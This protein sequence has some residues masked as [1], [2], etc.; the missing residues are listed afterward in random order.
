LLLS[1]GL[2]LLIA[3]GNV[4]NLLLGEARGREHE[5]AMR[6]ALGA[7][8]GRIV[9]QLVI[10]SLA[11]SGLGGILG[12][13]VA[14]ISLRGLV[15]L[16][17]PGL[18]RINEIGVDARILFFVTLLSA[19]SGIIF[20][21]APALTLAG[22]NLVDTLKN[23]GQQKGSPRSRSQALVVVTEISM[24]FVLLVGPGLLARSLMQLNA[25]DTGFNPVNLLAVR[26][27]LP[28]QTYDGTKVSALY[29]QMSAELSSLPGISAVTATDGAPFQD[30]R[31][32]STATIDGKPA[33]LETRSIWPNYFE[34][35]G[36][37]FLEGRTFSEAEAVAKPAPGPL[38]VVINQTMAQRFWPQEKAT[39]KRIEYNK[40]AHPPVIG[41][42]DDVRQLGLAVTPPPMFYMPMIW[43][44][45]FTLLIRTTQNPLSVAPAVRNRIRSI[46]KNIAI[47]WI[48]PI[49]E[50]IRSS[51]I[52]ERYRALLIAMFALSAA[53]LAVVGLYGVMSRYVA[54]R[55]RE[56]G[57]RL[58]I[59]AQPRGVMALVLSKGLILTACGIVIGGIAAAW[60]TRVLSTYLFGISPLDTPTYVAVA[61]LLA[62]I[63]IAAVIYPARRASRIDPAECLRAE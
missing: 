13:V 36:G 24:C 19:A 25:V 30:R 20:G 39:D 42:T 10:E 18:P 4:A 50:M 51:L 29:R 22:T 56:F 63:S 47:D 48:E 17:P 41:V 14:W 46:D 59:G 6:S 52:E 21:L 40:D 9:R 34:V 27:A 55:N 35:L 3:C 8:T 16:A 54:Y 60:T 44:T 11:I 12:C 45:D 1:S 28:R 15:A 57:I 58:A 23:R 26:V 49:T 7:S 2:L 53:L 37:R 33:V 61:L 38:A 31:S 5:V 32:V 62:I 43:E